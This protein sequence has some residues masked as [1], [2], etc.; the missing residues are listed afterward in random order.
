MAQQIGP[1]SFT[2]WHGNLVPAEQEVSL[3]SQPNVDGFG[4]LFGAYRAPPRRIVT[5]V[6]VSTNEQAQTLIRQY[7]LQKDTYV[8][9]TIIDQYNLVW[10]ETLI[11]RVSAGDPDGLWYPFTVLG[12]QVITAWELL[13]RSDRPS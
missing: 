13:V 4:A 5:K 8:K 7:R 12:I 1:F 2:V 10:P 6:R 9:Q 3:F 11:L